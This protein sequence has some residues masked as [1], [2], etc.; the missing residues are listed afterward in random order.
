MDWDE[1]IAMPVANAAN[2][3]LEDQLAQYQKD[4]AFNAS[5]INNHNER[6]HH[7]QE[8]LKN[9]RQELTHNLAL[10]SAHMKQV[11]TEEHLHAIADR[12]EGRLKQ[13]TDKQNKNLELIREKRNN[14]ENKIFAQS[15]QLEELKAQMNW[16]QQALEAWLEESAR[17][18][19]DAI[20]LQKYS[21]Q[22]NSKLKELALLIEH[23]TLE[24][25]KKRRCLDQETT[26]TLTAQIEMDKTAEEFRKAHADRQNLINQWEVTIEQMQRRDNEMDIAAGDLAN[27]KEEVRLREQLIKEKQSFLESELEN[28]QE[29]EKK[30]SMEERNAAKFRIDLQEHEN[31]RSQLGNELDTL[32]YTVER[33]ASDLEAMK[34]NVTSLK[35]DIISK[36]EKLKSSI[37]LR[38]Q[39]QGKLEAVGKGALS[40]EDRAAMADAAFAQEEEDVVQL[41]A[42]LRKTREIH[43]KKKQMVFDAL[44]NEKDLAAA[45]QGGRAANRNLS[46]RLKT[47][48][49]QSIQQQEIVYNQDFTI[50]T[51][52]RRLARLMGEVDTEEKRELEA[53]IVELTKTLEEKTGVQTMLTAQLKRLQDDIRRQKRDMEKSGAE[54]SDLTSKIEE[55]NLHNEISNKELRN[56]INKKQESMVEDNILKLEVRRIQDY[57]H[58]KADQVL[59]LEKRSLQLSTAMKERQQEISMHKEML[60]SQLKAAEEERQTVSAE[61]HMRTEKIDKLKKRYEILM[62]SMA[63]PEGEEAKSQAYYVIKAAQDKEELQRNG[64]ELDA[65][66]RKAEKEIRALENTLRLMNSRNETYRKTFNKVTES[67][68]EYEIKQQLDEQFRSVMDKYKYKRRQIRELQE[69]VQTMSSAMDTT[70]RDET[71]YLEMVQDRKSKIQQLQKDIEDQGVKLERVKKQ[72]SRVTREARTAQ[73]AKGPLSEE[74]DMEIREIRDRNRSI[75]KAIGQILQQF[76]DLTQTVEMHFQQVGLPVPQPPGSRGSSRASSVQS[77]ARSS[78]R[79]SI[80]SARSITSPKAVDLTLGLKT[81]APGPASGPPSTASSRH[82][83]RASSRR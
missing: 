17:R 75:S 36:N 38:E 35:K 11:E 57:L 37:S 20:T 15:Q 30:I 51:L 8:H 10:M 72:I 48:D 80:S 43:F 55:L 52:E 16:D 28:N 33:T 70:L 32:K 60:F 74:S 77:S 14:F 31:V 2:K 61:L 6:I 54:K 1:G 3:L 47:L 26:E 29:M 45:I 24:S 73:G 34:S 42:T 5:D 79:S 66:I 58:R 19:E 4:I 71:A 78:P 67:S 59:S 56:I 44:T 63:P 7:M 22:D 21:N 81:T 41:E 46:S 25:Q 13:E 82:S 49:T 69:D 12:E 68:E 39:L 53:K 23:L 65:R 76:P 18:D 64:D 27:V 50:Q 62:V 40:A 83:S 9:V